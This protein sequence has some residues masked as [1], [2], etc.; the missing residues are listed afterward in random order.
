MTTDKLHSRAR[1]RNAGLT[2]ERLKEL[3]HYDPDTGIFTWRVDRG[4]MRCKGA[5]T[6]TP[7]AT[8]Y[9]MIRV[10]YVIYKAH[11]LAWLYMTG[12]WPESIVDH[13]NGNKADNC[14]NNLRSATHVLN[15]ANSRRR[16]T[17]KRFRG[18][19]FNKDCP[20]RPYS[21][22]IGHDNQRIYLGSFA[23]AEE[24]YAAYCKEARLLRGNF[25]RLD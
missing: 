24:A 2:T 13:I 11:R 23:T 16:S 7:D 14:W 3:L 10:D 5:R 6:G 17:T 18:V 8:G 15:A 22:C 25:A 9:L 4:A 20:N 1:T 12:K 19:R 21:V